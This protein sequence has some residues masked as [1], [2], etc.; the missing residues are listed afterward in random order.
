MPRPAAGNSA[1]LSPMALAKRP[2]VRGEAISALTDMEPADWPKTVMLAGWPAERRRGFGASF[3]DGLGE[4]ARGEG[5]GHQ[6]AD[7]HGAGGLAEDSDVGGIAAEGGDVAADPGDGGGLVEQA[8]FAGG[9]VGG[10]GGELGV[11]E[12]AE[13]AEA[14]VH[15]DDDDAAMGEEFPVLAIQIG[16]ASWR[17]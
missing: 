10:F 4:K 8:V 14:V 7:G 11:N 17:E 6:R 1:P 5:R 15:A 13:D 16:R 9:V 12:E 2:A 3:A